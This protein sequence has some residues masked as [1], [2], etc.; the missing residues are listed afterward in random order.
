M[1]KKKIIIAVVLIIVGLAGIYYWYIIKNNTDSNTTE[2]QNEP[3]VAGTTAESTD[4]PYFSQ[5]AKVMLFYSE[6]C[7]WCI[8]QKDVLKELVPDGYRV[9]PMD[10]GKNQNYWQEYQITGTPTLI[11]PDGTKLVGYQDKE[12]LKEFLDKYK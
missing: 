11:A 8:K 12:K 6:Y 3:K 1:D 7:S 4:Q 10:V 9:K 2:N 5:D